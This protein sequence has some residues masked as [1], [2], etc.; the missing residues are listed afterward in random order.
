[1]NKLT[2]VSYI[3]QI[4]GG[5]VLAGIAVYCFITNVIVNG[6]IFLGVGAVFI[7]MPI[8]SIYKARKQKREEEENKN[9]GN[10][11]GFL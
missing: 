10:K 5:L 9:S 3:L 4:V 2:L 7:V 1:M 11:R 6:V 8:R